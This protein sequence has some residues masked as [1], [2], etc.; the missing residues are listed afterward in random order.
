VHRSR[1]RRLDDAVMLITSRN[2]MPE[3]RQS[4]SERST[5]QHAELELKARLDEACAITAPVSEESTAELIRLEE[6]L[7]GAADA[8]KETVSL[9][10]RLGSN[11]HSRA[12]SDDLSREQEASREPESNL[13]EFTDSAGVAWKVWE[14]IPGLTRS[15]TFT[16]DFVA[17][18]LCFETADGTVSRRLP[19]HPPEWRS[20]RPEG[21]ERLLG[22]ARAS[23]RKGV[24]GDQAD[25]ADQTDQT[26]PI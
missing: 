25:Q 12:T 2:A 1:G 9:R 21:L 10:Q 24:R 3:G 18:W 26:D 16:A 4:E 15:A 20:L 13:R 7:S 5:L 22:E 11:G 17:G 19:H 14:V 8:A 23:R 6:A